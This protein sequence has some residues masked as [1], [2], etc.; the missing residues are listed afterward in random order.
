ML[1]LQQ[2]TQTAEAVL[3]RD[4]TKVAQRHPHLINRTVDAWWS[5]M[6]HV[7]QVDEETRALRE[8]AT[9]SGVETVCEVGFNAGH[10]AVLFLS[11]LR[12][13]LIEFDKLELP[14][15]QASK[16]LIQT[17]F[18]NRTTFYHGGSVRVLGEYANRSA[19]V[20]TPEYSRR[21][22]CDLWFVD[23]MH[24][25][26]VPMHDLTNALRVSSPNAIIVAD[27]CTD[28][29]PEVSQAWWSL[30][31]SGQLTHETYRTLELPPPAGRKGWCV[32]RP[33]KS[34]VPR[35]RRQ[36]YLQRRE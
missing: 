17:L 36:P 3:Q 5:T 27:D 29:F 12:T 1:H 8:L 10:S 2:A 4:W 15:S 6:G 30:V 25:R 18:P 19:T 33:A 23:G 22:T 20:A 32:G 13:R 35:R 9:R 28:R 11:G 26:G 34:S 24:G 21:P 14:Y 16:E 31:K 7:G